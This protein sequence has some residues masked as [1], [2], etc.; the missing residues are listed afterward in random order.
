MKEEERNWKKERKE[1][2][3]KEETKYD[4]WEIG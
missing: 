2:G 3:R 1:T 4:E